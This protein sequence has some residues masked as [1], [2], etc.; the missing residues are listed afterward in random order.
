M[1]YFHRTAITLYPPLRQL[2]KRLAPRDC[3]CGMSSHLTYWKSDVTSFNDVKRSRIKGNIRANCNEENN[4]LKP[5]LVRFLGH[6]QNSRSWYKVIR[7]RVRLIIV[8]STFITDIP[9]SEPT[10]FELLLTNTS[11]TRKPLY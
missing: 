6:L 11:I 1:K 8:I 10:I 7:R 5:S 4:H 2:T 3:W 9:K